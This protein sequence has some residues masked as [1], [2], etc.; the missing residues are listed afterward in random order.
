MLEPHELFA[1]QGF[2]ADYRIGAR[3]DGSPRPKYQQVAR[4]GNSVSPMAARALVAA[5]YSQTAANEP[6]V[7]SNLAGIKR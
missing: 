6:A 4:C 5:N 1:A 2:P 3:L 7:K